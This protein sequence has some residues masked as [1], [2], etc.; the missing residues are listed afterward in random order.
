[1]SLGTF[2]KLVE[3]QTKIASVFPF[4]I[5]LL[6]VIYRYDLF[7]PINT[8]IFFSAMLLFDLT[9]TAINNY[10]DYRKALNVEYKKNRNIIGEK[11]IPERVVII[12]ILSL[13]VIATSLG[14]WL[15][16][17]TDL[18]V[19]VIG[20]VC[21]AI[22]IFYTFGPIPLSRMPLGEVFSGVTMGFGIIFLVVYVNAYDQGIAQFVWDG[23]LIQFNAN[24]LLILE[25]ILISL[26]C[27]FTIANLML[28][29]NICDLEDDIANHRY[30]LP[31][32]IGKKYAVWLF[33]GLYVAS[34]LAVIVAVVLNILPTVMLLMLFVG[35]PVYRHIRLFN[36]KQVKSE[37]FVVAVKNLVL[38]NGSLVTML[39][40]SLLFI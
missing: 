13:L 11:A 40:V 26:P 2:F 37:T 9:T 24:I 5:G 34:F 15:V 38:V 8:M 16:V 7:D 29:N 33:D 14:L 25:I 23:A 31:F 27:V 3:I 12:T 10:M 6:F 17:R 30:T 32:Y 19:L 4:L 20:M 39:L 22:G 21:F 28:A 18:L 1:M 36:K 35:I